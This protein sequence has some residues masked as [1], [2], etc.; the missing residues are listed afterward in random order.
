MFVLWHSKS[1]VYGKSG[2]VERI[3]NNF[4]IAKQNNETLILHKLPCPLDYCTSNPL[5]VT[6]S[7]TSVQCDFNRNGTLCGQCQKNVSL[8]LGSLHCIPCDNTN[9]ALIVPFALTGIALVALIFLLQLT[10]S[11]GTL[12][13]LFFYV[14]IIQANHQAFFPREKIN[15][16]TVFISW[17][18]LDLGIETCFYNG[19]DIYAYSWFQF[20][21]PFYVWFLVGCIILACRYS[22]SIA[23]RLG[24]NPVAVLATLLLMSYSKILGAVIVPLTWTY[25]TYYTASN[26]T[27]R[28]SV[29][30][31]YDASIP[32]FGEPKHT[33]LGLFAILCI[34]VFVLPYISLLFCGHWLQGCSNWQILSWLN[35]IKPFMDAYHAPC[36]KHARYWTGLLLLSRLGLFLSFAN[37]IESVNIAAVALVTVA[38]LA[39]RFRVY[40]H[41]Y[42]D[43]LE[44]SFILNLGIFSVVTFYINEKS[45]DAAKS[46]LILSSISVGITFITFF[47]ILLFHISLVLKSS[48]IW[49][50]YMLPFIQKSLLLSKILR[51][52]PV[53][54]QTRAGD[55]DAAELQTLPTSTEIDIDLREPLL[56]ITES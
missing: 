47:G 50:N 3:K 24:K 49:K 55:K 23:K 5:N 51:I 35:K 31:M 42:N 1:S 48:N 34:A 40:E 45:E 52:T 36:R 6:L 26:E 19:M 38:L 21:F 11:V 54:D 25:L 22:Q 12:N 46:Q 4:W 53:K 33:A 20:L 7:D 27:R 39:I 16:F 18:N 37:D 30:W 29:V 14:N 41:F 32:Y 10:V 2:I 44:S 15:F 9:I 28:R 13:G 56:E 8:A 17:L 43:V